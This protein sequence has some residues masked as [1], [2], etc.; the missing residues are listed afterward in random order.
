[1]KTF[2]C[3]ITAVLLSVNVFGEG[4][5]FTDKS[6]DEVWAEANAAYVNANYGDA[7]FK[8]ESLLARGIDSWVL[9]YNLGNACFKDGRIAKAILNYNRAQRLAPANSDIAYNLA[10]ANA[11]VKDKIEAMPVFFAKRWVQQLQGSLSSNSWAFMSL[12]FF[13][14][15]LAAL[16]L[17]LL[18]S[19][20]SLRK[21]GFYGGILCLLLF[22]MSLGFSYS[23][24]KQI[25][26]PTQ[27]VV[28]EDAV[29]V[30]SSPDNG[31]KDIFVL[32]AGTKV[33]VVSELNGWREIMISDGNKGWLKVESIEMI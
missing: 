1:M 23:E 25:T 10:I 17:Y 15:F 29:P 6:N 12:V 31:S 26:D 14:L 9:Y 20:L 2:V 4:G 28:M 27:A 30:K 32:H 13:A 21:T 18:M 7:I 3:L 19:R 33:E 24:K 11:Y 16:I 8:Y 5:S 22:I